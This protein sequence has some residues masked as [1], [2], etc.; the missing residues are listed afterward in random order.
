[1][2]LYLIDVLNKNILFF[3]ED[4]KLISESEFIDRGGGS[5]WVYYWSY[6]VIPGDENST[7]IFYRYNSNDCELR[8][9]SEGYCLSEERRKKL[10]KKSE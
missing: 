8:V 1:M 5:N 9:F 7:I 4:D 10:I 3:S 6:I 2:E